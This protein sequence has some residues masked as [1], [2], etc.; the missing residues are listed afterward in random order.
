MRDQ[1]FFFYDQKQSKSNSKVDLTSFINND[2]FKL[3]VKLHSCEN[4]LFS[5]S[6]SKSWERRSSGL[7]YTGGVTYAD[8]LNTKFVLSLPKVRST[9]IVED[10]VSHGSFDISNKGGDCKEKDVSSDQMQYIIR[11]D[12]FA[13]DFI[14]KFNQITPSWFTLSLHQELKYIHEDNI[15]VFVWPAHRVKS[16]EVCGGA[17]I[18]ETSTFLVYLHRE[19]ITMKVHDV[20]VAMTTGSQFCLLVDICKKE[21]H[22]V[23]PADNHDQFKPLFSFSNI[24]TLGWKMSLKSVGFKNGVTSDLRKC[25]RH[26]V[27]QVLFG[28]AVLKYDFKRLVKGAISG[29]L[30]YDLVQQN[31]KEVC[32]KFEISFI[33]MNIFSDIYLLV[34]IHP[35]S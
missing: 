14:S 30:T 31:G 3:D 11:N 23:L 26:G 1:L 15:R 2:C 28:S 9:Q 33:F 19:A 35:I 4:T 6:S 20:S 27:N 13:K 34:I 10:I 25:S 21:P 7:F 5:I 29:V 16:H 22:F 12:L 8:I 24:Q 17:A 18:D 32:K